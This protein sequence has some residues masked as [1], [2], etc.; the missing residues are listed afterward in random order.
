[1]AIKQFD[2]M[3]KSKDA[4]S[5]ILKTINHSNRESILI[6]SLTMAL[7]DDLIT[8]DACSVDFNKLEH[9]AIK[10]AI[11][12]L[13][14]ELHFEYLYFDLEQ[15]IRRF[16]CECAMN[17]SRNNL[18]DEFVEKYAKQPEELKLYVD[19]EN[20]V[21]NECVD[22]PNIRLLPYP[23]E[24]VNVNDNG[25]FG[26]TQCVAEVTVRG[27]DAVRMRE[28]GL[29]IINF[30]LRILRVGLRQHPAIH[31][32]QLRFRAGKGWAIEDGRIGWIDHVDNGYSIGINDNLLDIV[33]RQ[34]IYNLKYNSIGKIN[35]K[36]NLA[37]QW[38]ELSR[39]STDPLLSLLYD[40]F[41]LETI[42]GDK[43]EK[44]KA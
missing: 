24:Y 43:K 7:P 20:L 36:V 9:D 21:Q 44:L 31:D 22:L 32:Q 14:N 19:I 29:E 39:L 41:A 27:T 8:K 30:D 6:P 4:L 12:V 34:P 5:S 37:I 28:R 11:D 42:L 33:K 2:E 38:V 23:S 25:Y 26:K 35:K 16:A 15:I 3:K 40:M 10:N 17:K 1:M 13:L 18:V